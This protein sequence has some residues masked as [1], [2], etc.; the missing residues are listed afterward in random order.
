MQREQLGLD[1]RA[2][3]PLGIEPRLRLG[4]IARRSAGEHQTRYAVGELARDHAADR[5]EAGDGDAV[6][7]MNE[8]QA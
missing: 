3:D 8:P 2:G 1:Q 5:A 4:V 7:G 6:T